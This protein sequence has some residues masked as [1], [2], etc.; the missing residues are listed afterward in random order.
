MRASGLK[1]SLWWGGGLVW[2]VVFVAG[3]GGAA[4]RAAEGSVASAV[5]PASLQPEASVE[6]IRAYRLPNGLQVLLAPDASKQ[7]TTVNITY[8]VGSRHEHYGETGMAHLLEHLLFKGTPSL[9]G[10][11]IVQEFARRG[12]Q[13][14]GSTFYD[15]TNYH[16]TFA[17]SEDNLDWALQMEADRM[18]N[19]FI[20][21]ADLDSE[22]TVVRN[23]MEAGENDPGGMLWQ[24]M[25]ATAYQW[26]NYGKS[27]IGARSDVENV[28]IDKLQA[29][30]RTYYQPD[31]AVLVVAGNFDE[32]RALARI[33]EYFGVIP[34]PARVLPPTYTRDPAQEGA[35]EV[36]LSRVGDTRLLGAMY[37]I[38]A[39]A[40]PDMA[41][42]HLLAY[43]LGDSPSG[44]LHRA[45]VERKLAA[46]ADVEVLSLKEPGMLMAFLQL[47]K[48]QSPQAARRVLLAELE[49][50][51]QRPVTEAEL[52]RARQALKNAYEQALDDPAHFGV[53]LS[54]SIALG[55]WRLFFLERDRIEAA[56]LAEVQGVAERYLLAAN[57]TLGEFIPTA[58]PQ[59]A[60]IPEAPDLDTMLADYRGRAE[61]AAGE[62]FDAS[63]LNIE[64]R[65]QRSTL[66]NGMQV[67]LLAKRTRGNTVQGSLILRLGDAQALRG[68]KHLAALTAAML[69]RGAQGLTRQQIA[70]RL[71]ALKAQ[72]DISGQDGIVTVAF[73]TR[74]EQLSAFLDLLR[75]ILRAPHFSAA[76]FD[77]L[78]SQW[79]TALEA[80]RSQPESLAGRALA[81]HDNPY[82]K[83]DVRYAESVE[84]Q[85]A[86][87]KALR[88]AELQ[89]FHRAFYGAA[90]AQLALVG[91]FDAPAVASQVKRLFGDWRARQPV[92]RISTPFRAHTG[93]QIHISAPDK[94]NAFFVARLRLPLR[95]DSPDAAALAIANRVLGG[96][97]LKSRL[98]DRLRH[99]EGLSYDVGAFLQL[100]AYEANSVLGLYA[101]YAPG[102]LDRLQRGLNEEL[103][104]FVRDGITDQELQDAR[105]GLLEAAR[106]ARTQDG[107]LARALASQLYQQ[108]DMHFTLAQEARL[109]ALTVDDVNAAIRR[110]L[111]PEN[112][113][114]VFAG[115]FTTPT[116]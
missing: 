27:T 44:R 87:I 13:F 71:D 2:L 69:M 104:R 48:T 95:D 110:H 81:R 22:M 31:N 83:G 7:T 112:F 82:P 86:A 101:I 89:T 105:N 100:N 72:L 68:K 18:V 43:V 102:N 24:Q 116:P 78:R 12:M 63:P 16:E 77:Q 59:R 65:T 98:A 28:Q 23:E 114:Q 93:E 79:L 36:S 70:D 55:D 34:R 57:R 39:G 25:M 92:D 42:L 66:A 49:G 67:A 62:A 111:N 75:T 3:L 94:A 29:F 107:A 9:P 85:L 51:R 45:L 54:E 99:Q 64:Q 19:S 84:E 103:A 1:R 97:S 74:R 20:A 41:A 115:D 15:R 106:I 52:R 30:Y 50:L 35:R 6:G 10:K 80:E 38:P 108:R 113:V 91:D 4:A 11:T 109:Q 53:A 33:A 8:K 17:A 21:R 14:N 32:A 37:H 90:H 5:A 58:K 47:D 46:S 61:L 40:H 76:E 88:L 96:G 60:V 56:T 73:E 26:H